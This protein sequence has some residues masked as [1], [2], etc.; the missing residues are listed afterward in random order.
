[1]QAHLARV[2]D[3]IQLRTRSGAAVF[4]IEHGLVPAAER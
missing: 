1:V 4:A 3:K 2:Y